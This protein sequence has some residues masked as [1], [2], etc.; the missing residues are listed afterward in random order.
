MTIRVHDVYSV[1]LKAFARSKEEFQYE[2]FQS[3]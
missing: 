3:I 1:V 2:E